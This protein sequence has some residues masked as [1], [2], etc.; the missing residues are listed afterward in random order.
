MSAIPFK[1]VMDWLPALPAAK[2]G[3]LVSDKDICVDML[4]QQITA[5]HHFARD[6]GG[7]LH[8]F[9]GGVYKPSGESFVKQAVKTIYRASGIVEK[10]STH[11]ANEVVEYIRVDCPELWLDIPANTMNVLNGLVDVASLKL[12]PHSPQFYSTVQIPVQFDPAAKCP[13]WDQFIS[14]VFPPD[15]EAVAWEILAWLM[16]TENSIQKAVL[17]LGEGSNGK[18][19][20][21]RACTAFIGKSN[22]AALSLHK[23]EQDKFA[24]ARLMSKLANICPDLPTAHLSSTSMFKALTGGDVLTAE[25]KF[26]DSFEYLPFCKLVFSANKPPQSDDSTHGF[27]RRWLV[28]SFTRCFE[29]GVRDTARREDLDARLAQPGELSGVLNKALLALKQI[30]GKGFTQADSMTQA[31]DEFRRATDPLSVWLDQNTVQSP[32]AMVAKGEL[33]ASYSRYCTASGKALMTTSA[34]GLALK[35]LRTGLEE[36]QRTLNGKVQWV[37]LGIGMRSDQ[38]VE[39]SRASRT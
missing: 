4:A 8:V 31:W 30:R 28:I 27:F 16:T 33:I 13:A 14:E 34:F 35:R 39:A 21:L 26:K 6:A 9:K 32:A 1:P 2:G 11:K 25:Y 37:Y 29:E 7:R 23:L 36:G 20:Y 22:T 18:S 38:E 17:L 5:T 15:A 10:W 24:A 12:R 19:T 3:P